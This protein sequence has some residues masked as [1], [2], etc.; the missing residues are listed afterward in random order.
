MPQILSSGK[1]SNLP[2][3]DLRTPLGQGV[4]FLKGWY[5]DELFSSACTLRHSRASGLGRGST[6]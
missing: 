6:G 1:V 2:F 5:L 4:I 3:G